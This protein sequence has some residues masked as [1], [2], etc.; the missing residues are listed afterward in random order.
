M[1]KFGMQDKEP[2][3]E[4]NSFLYYLFVKASS[5]LVWPPDNPGRNLIPEGMVR[6]HSL[7]N[8][9]I[10]LPDIH[11]RAHE[12]DA[13]SSGNDVYIRTTEGREVT[14]FVDDLSDL[15][16]IDLSK[17]Q[18]FYGFVQAD[19]FSSEESNIAISETEKIHEYISRLEKENIEIDGIFRVIKIGRTRHN[20][21]SR[22]E[23]LTKRG[24]Q[25]ISVDYSYILAKIS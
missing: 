22:N 23:R 9:A 4:I 8:E 16:G 20:D 21:F 5:L 3:S 15:R 10:D 1:S 13:K 2:I 12:I 7:Y 14:K 19:I 18:C 17:A 6:L 25:R 11:F 24:F